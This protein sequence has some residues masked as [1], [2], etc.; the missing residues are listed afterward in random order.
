LGSKSNILRQ[1]KVFLSY[2]ALILISVCQK[3]HHNQSC[4]K[5]QSTN[6]QTE[7]EVFC[8]SAASLLFATMSDNDPALVRSVNID[9]NPSSPAIAEDDD[10]FRQSVQPDINTLEAKK[11]GRYFRMNL[12]VLLVRLT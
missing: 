7:N 5:P 11:I 10:H 8:N 1:N 6:N 9:M 2:N 3:V 12:S 4:C